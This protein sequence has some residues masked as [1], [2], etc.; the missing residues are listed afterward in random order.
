[1]RILALDCAVGFCSATIVVDDA[2]LVLRERAEARDHATHLPIMVRDCLADA[3]L[4]V[5]QLDGIAV[6]V[7]S[8]SFTGIRTGL[9]LAQG[10]SVATGRR[11]VGVT[12][13]EALIEALHGVT[14]RAVWCVTESRR[15]RVFLETAQ[16]VQSLPSEA[17]PMPNQPV[18]LA[19]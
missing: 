15:G 7:G 9:A 1:M 10:L 3:K 4:T 18:I 12:V 13:G 2:V 6:T 14:A 19:G 17:L 8:G 5:G 11:L 16:G